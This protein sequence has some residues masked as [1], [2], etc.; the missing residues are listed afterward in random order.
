MGV[1]IPNPD[2]NRHRI[3]DLEMKHNELEKKYNEAL[4]IVKDTKETMAETRRLS[5]KILK[6]NKRNSWPSVAHRIIDGIK[7]VFW[8]I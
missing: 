1:D 2:N 3:V 7:E 8:W 5:E 4:K 6:E